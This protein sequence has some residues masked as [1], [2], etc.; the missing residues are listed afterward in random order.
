MEGRSHTT[1]ARFIKQTRMFVEC[2]IRKL[3]KP[4]HSGYGIVGDGE[5][6][7]YS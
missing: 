4:K 3:Q 1:G 5:T 7:K 6:V 2:K